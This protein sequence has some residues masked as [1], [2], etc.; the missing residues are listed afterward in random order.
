MVRLIVDSSG[1]SY[2]VMIGTDIHRELRG[3]VRRLAPSSVAIIADANVARRARTIAKVVKTSSAKT[4]IHVVRAGERAKSLAGLGDVLAFLERQNV[5]R[6]GCIIAVGG[7]TVG[8]LAGF[9][10]SIWL[11]GIRLIAV[12]TT[13]LA[14]VDS[15]V[16]GKTGINGLRSKNAVG[17]FWPPSAVVADTAWLQTLP[18]VSYRDAFA[19][20]VKYGVAMDRGL[21]ELL[22]VERPRLL[23]R[24]RRILE[25]VVFRCVTAKAL[26]VAKDER[27]RGPRA[28]LN[29]GHTAGHA[30]EAAS[31][32][33]VSHG[34]A[35]A[36]G[37]R[38]AARIALSLDLCGPRLVAAQ[39]ALLTDYGLPD[40]PP[41]VDA[42]RVLAA[43]PH[44]KKARNGKVA[45]V[46]PRRLG[47][48]ETGHAVPP[49]LV[50]KVVRRAL[51]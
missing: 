16:G 25:R 20:V 31:R 50:R 51:G 48:A 24:D 22:Q 47:H 4:S 45:W 11:R 2:P 1:G 32:F 37:M 39:D 6:A 30:L 35:V 7:G 44:D 9:A 3:I 42:A 26:V 41:A 40:R 8:D 17:T 10:A 43:I 12:P 29:Y 49:A 13:L 34:R 15:S 28:I 18:P 5:D 14:M 19:E 21:F 46:M 23:A 36:F 27:E 33:R 38:V